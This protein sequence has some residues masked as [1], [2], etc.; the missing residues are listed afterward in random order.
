MKKNLILWVHGLLAALIGGSA[1]ALLTGCA[2]GKFNREL[3][4]AAAFGG[5]FHAAMY[6]AKSPIFD[7]PGDPVVPVVP[8]SGPTINVTN[9]PAPAAEPVAPVIG[10]TTQVE[11]KH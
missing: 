6:L 2:I 7:L 5:V 10:P 4:V 1:T 9:V 8:V 11:E 3:F